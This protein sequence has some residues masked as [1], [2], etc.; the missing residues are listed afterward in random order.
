MNRSSSSRRRRFAGLGQRLV[1]C[2]LAVLV[3]AGNVLAS[4]VLLLHAH[5]DEGLHLHV[6][7][8]AALS[9]DH[10]HEG[11]HG[12]AGQHDHHADHHGDHGHGVKIGHDEVGLCEAPPGVVVGVPALP[13]VQRDKT[14]LA[15]DLLAMLSWEPVVMPGGEALRAFDAPPPG[16]DDGPGRPPPRSG[17]LGVLRSSHALL[18]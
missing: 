2:V 1:A 7:A 5:G 6:L 11:E 3:L 15:R 13:V 10:R 8:G 14:L 17:V 16:R 18:I 9:T 12:H 4:G